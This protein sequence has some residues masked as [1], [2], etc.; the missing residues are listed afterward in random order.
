MHGC[1]HLDT[2]SDELCQLNTRVVRITRRHVVMGGFTMS[3]SPQALE[4]EGDDGGY[5]DDCF[6][7]TFPLSFVT[8]MRSSFRYESS[9]I[10]RGRPFCL[11]ECFCLLEGCSEDFCI[12]SFLYLVDTLSLVLWYCDH[13]VIENFV[14][15]IYIYI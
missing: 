9:Y 10:L 4:D 1:A 6:L 12:F 14:F 8:K 13:L 2:L 3:P 5:G 15:I 7:M 11:G